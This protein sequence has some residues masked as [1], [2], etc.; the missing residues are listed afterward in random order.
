MIVAIIIA[1]L[2]MG[3]A[4]AVLWRRSEKSGVSGEI[5]GGW[6][7]STGFACL[8]M[9]L[10]PGEGWLPEPRQAI[11]AILASIWSYRL[12]RHI[13]SRNGPAGDDPRYAA[14]RRQWQERASVRMFLF[15]QSQAVAGLILAFSVYVVAHRD[16][17]FPD[18]F[19]L[20]GAGVAIFALVNEA[21]ADAQLAAYRHQKERSPVCEIGWWG[22]SRHPN[23][24]F[25]FLFWFGLAM[26]GI[27]WRLD[28]LVG[29]LA[30][31]APAMMYH[32]LTKV[33]GIPPL[34]EH[35][36]ASRGEAYRDYMERVPPFFPK[37]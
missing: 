16:S 22:R 10:W 26:I 7:L 35:M 1:A 37:W 2:W 27:D 4:M 25:E 23:Y 6:A 8:I 14:L 9:A 5:D 11:V 28:E 3:L 33:S 12:G 17:E 31:V 18:L 34:E 20:I 15:L 29:L 21:R 36:L 32:L 19:D 24:F 30:F 13:F